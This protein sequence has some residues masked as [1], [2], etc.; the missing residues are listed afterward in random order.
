MRVILEWAVRT[1][2]VKTN[3]FDGVEKLVTE[4]KDRLVTG[5]ELSLAVEIGIARRSTVHSGNG[6]PDRVALRP[7]FGR[8]SRNDARSDR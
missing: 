2:G 4:K 1:R 8:G 3:P 6:A 5:D 7:P